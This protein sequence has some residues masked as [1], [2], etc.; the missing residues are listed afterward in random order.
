[1]WSSATASLVLLLAGVHAFVP[2]SLPQHLCRHSISSSSAGIQSKR[3]HPCTLGSQSSNDESSLA[4]AGAAAVE[5]RQFIA[6]AASAC[7]VLVAGSPEGCNAIGE[8]P[9]TLSQKRFVQH[10]VVNVPD[11]EAAIRFYTEGLGMRVVRSRA[12]TSANTNTTFVAYGPEQ[13]TV[14]KDWAPGVSSFA[15]YGGHFSLELVGPLNPPADGELPFYDPGNGVQY[16]QIAVDTYRI[17]KVIAAGGEVI[18]GYGGLKINLFS[19]VRR[20]PMMFVALKVSDLKKSVQWYTDVLGMS[21][22]PYPKAREAV[23]SV[24]EPKQPKGSVFMGYDEDGS[25]VLLIP[26]DKKDKAPI[27]VGSAYSKLAVLATDVE[28]E[29]KRVGAMY[30][31]KAPGTSTS[32]AVVADPDGYTTVLVEYDDFAREL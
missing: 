9:E 11:I 32:V 14:P 29:G 24:F 20:D 2:S 5:R 27:V 10:A 8:L 15:A 23:D 17:S 12:D 7:A 18:F 26:K 25:G 28:D 13:L 21:Q 22:F 4:G 1:M 30:A 19:G 3:Q 6:A 16:I 31:G